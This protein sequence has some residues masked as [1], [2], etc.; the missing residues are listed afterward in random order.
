MIALGE[1]GKGLYYEYSSASINHF[2]AYW[3][4]GYRK[5]RDFAK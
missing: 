4:C 2:L 3:Y 1:A 5:R